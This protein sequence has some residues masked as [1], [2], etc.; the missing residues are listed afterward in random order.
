MCGSRGLGTPL[1]GF[2]IRLRGAAAERFDCVYE[3]AFVSGYHSATGQNGS[4]C[5][6]DAIGDPLEGVLLRIVEKQ[7]AQPRPF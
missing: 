6:S 7:S 5:R 2:S 3:G 4:P 1:I